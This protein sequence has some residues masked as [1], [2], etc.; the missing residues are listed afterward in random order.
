MRMSSDMSGS[1]SDKSYATTPP[2]QVTKTLPKE[3]RPKTPIYISVAS[4][5]RAFLPWLRVFCPSDLLSQLKGEK[6]IAIPLTA[7]G[8]EP[9]SQHCGPLIGERCKFPHL[10]TLGGQLCAAT[11]G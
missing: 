11:G 4:D 5:T 9:R 6:M 10:L 7:M 1:P 3:K 2:A 8:S